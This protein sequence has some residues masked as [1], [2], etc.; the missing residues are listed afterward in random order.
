MGRLGRP[1][2]R[3][4]AEPAKSRHAIAMGGAADELGYTEPGRKTRGRPE[5]RRASNMEQSKV[6]LE[7]GM[8]MTP[9]APR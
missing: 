3:G 4:D 5:A 6:G 8:V 9:I 2:P 1:G 7:I